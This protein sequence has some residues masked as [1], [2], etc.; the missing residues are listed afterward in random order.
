MLPVAVRLGDGRALPTYVG[1]IL[2]TPEE[3]HNFRDLAPATVFHF[4]V[5]GVAGFS[6]LY[7]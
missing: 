2:V 1:S 3:G 6:C 7:Y 5:M 4:S